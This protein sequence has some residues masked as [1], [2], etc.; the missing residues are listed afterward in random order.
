MTEATVYKNK[1]YVKSKNF[2]HHKTTIHG[3]SM[4]QWSYDVGINVLSRMTHSNP[5]LKTWG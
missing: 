4:L 3:G 2:I 5:G 1:L